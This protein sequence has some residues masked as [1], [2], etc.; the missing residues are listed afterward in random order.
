ME[1]DLANIHS[2]VPVVTQCSLFSIDSITCAYTSS[3]SKY[4]PPPPRLPISLCLSLTAKEQQVWWGPKPIKCSQ[5]LFKKN[6]K[7]L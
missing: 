1:P 7:K 3:P 2:L 5:V 4:H 6:N